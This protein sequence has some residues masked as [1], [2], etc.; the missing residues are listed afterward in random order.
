V[1]EKRETEVT[2]MFAALGA[3]LAVLAAGM[4]LWWFGRVT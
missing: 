1:V 2:A 4:S 3:V